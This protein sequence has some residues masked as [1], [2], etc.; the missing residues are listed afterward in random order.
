[1]K[2]GTN[3]PAMT[4]QR[5]MQISSN[6]ISRALAR[7]SSGKRINSAQD[8]P[9]GLAISTGLEAQA[10]GLSRA[11]QNINESY[12]A[13]AT[14]DSAIDI[15]T[16]IVQRMRELAIQS[17]NGSLSS[18]DRSYLDTE[19]QQLI[20]EFQRITA[21]TDFNGVKLLDGSFGTK[22]IQVGTTKGDSIG[23]TLPST[24]T[25][26]IFS[27][28]SSTTYYGTGSVTAKND[29]SMGSAP[30]ITKLGDINGDGYADMVT[31]DVVDDTISI[32]LGVGD[33]TF[34]S[35]FTVAADQNATDLAVA[36]FNNDGKYDFVTAN[37]SSN[38][39]SVYKNT[40]STTSVSASSFLITN[41]TTEGNAVGVAVG[42][43]NGDGY[44]DIA[45]IDTGANSYVSSFQNTGVGSFGARTTF[46]VAAFVGQ[47]ITA[48]NLN[49]DSRDDI[50]IG[51][52]AANRG[53]YKTYTSNGDKTFTLKAT[54]VLDSTGSAT[55]SANVS[56]II[57]SDV[58]NNGNVDILSYL[59]QGVNHTGIFRSL[60]NGDGTIAA[61]SKVV[62]LFNST[63]GLG[64]TD[65]TGD[66]YVDIIIDDPVNQT[67]SRFSGNGSGGFGTE[68][69]LNAVT[70]G[71][72]ITTG[73]VNGDGV[74]DIVTASSNSAN[75]VYVTNTT[76]T[77][78]YTYPTLSIATQTY[79]QNMLATLSTALSNLGSARATIG[80]QQSR[81]DYALVN[82][83]VMRE[84]ISQA[85][86]NIIDTD[87]ADESAELMKQQFLRQAQASVLTQAN[88]N[89]Q[90]V[91]QLLRF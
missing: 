45:T 58:N 38:T 65:I 64:V 73:D 51:G 85:R 60:G 24:Q 74:A 35:R 78:S 41:S 18:T 17:A 76:N 53:N 56:S 22:D 3:I 26:S 71:S 68:V 80:A 66:G 23:L 90:I 54:Q 63:G 91:L 50:V 84:N 70:N 8:D 5:Q 40:S 86:S 47:S 19:F 15:Q 11:I 82:D 49:N 52:R 77:I 10:R 34:Q 2:V 16:S 14:A 33:G 87:Y 25:N 46:S 6:A 37:G 20:A 59:D 44:K 72:F 21:Q 7:L 36:D 12:G 9:A 32:A 57:L 27:A 61:A 81:L 89:L 67:I 30:A 75:S 31:L 83:Q 43:F 1:M 39:I 29:V 55:A 79:A 88:M 62:A 28:T 4:A 13:L 48:G 42:D 69:V